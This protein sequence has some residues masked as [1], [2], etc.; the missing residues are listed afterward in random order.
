MPLLPV[1]AI[2]WTQRY[3]YLLS[4]EVLIQSSK[5]SCRDCRFVA[6]DVIELVLSLVCTFFVD[7]VVDQVDYAA[8][9]YG[10]E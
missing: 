8:E 9:R 10:K 1:R 4:L 2:P 6:E 3:A 7:V 5:N